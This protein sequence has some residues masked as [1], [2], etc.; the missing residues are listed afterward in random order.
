MWEC[1]SGLFA[2]GLR[3]AVLLT[4]CVWAIV[5]LSLQLPALPWDDQQATH[6]LISKFLTNPHMVHH[7]SKYILFW[8]L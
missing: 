4:G 8:V 6:S 5:A 7:Q 3:C 2:W 1:D